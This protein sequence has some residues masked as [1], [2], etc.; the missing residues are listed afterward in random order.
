MGLFP[1][2][3][4]EGTGVGPAASLHS[5]PYSHDKRDPEGVPG[6]VWD[7]SQSLN[8]LSSLEHG[9]PSPTNTSSLAT[10]DLSSSPQSRGE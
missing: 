10:L 5:R 1:V 9:G 2:M 8:F 4:S 6:V 3:L 7:S